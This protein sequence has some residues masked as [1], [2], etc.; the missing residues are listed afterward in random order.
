MVILNNPTL[1]DLVSLGTEVE[2]FTAIAKE[3]IEMPCSEA[4]DVPSIGLKQ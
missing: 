2:P 4:E 3:D 1:V